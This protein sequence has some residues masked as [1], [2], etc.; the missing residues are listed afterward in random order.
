M[1]EKSHIGHVNERPTIRV[2]EIGLS[3][4]RKMK[5]AFSNVPCNSAS[6]G[7]LATSPPQWSNAILRAKMAGKK[8]RCGKRIVEIRVYIYD[9]RPF[10]NVYPRNEIYRGVKY[11][12]IARE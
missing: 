5:T 4:A 6:H 12:T 8:S 9:S 3:V 11:I 7:M 10:A 2:D 1:R